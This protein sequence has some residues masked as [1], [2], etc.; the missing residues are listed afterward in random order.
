MTSVV[1]M[2]KPWPEHQNESRRARSTWWAKRDMSRE[3]DWKAL[4]P[5]I[6]DSNPLVATN[7][8]SRAC[9]IGEA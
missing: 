6:F 1:E 5:E 4:P 2:K 7:V 9:A 3:M 8:T